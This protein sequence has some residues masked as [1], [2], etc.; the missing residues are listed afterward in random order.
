MRWLLLTLC[1]V[2]CIGP[3]ARAG[4]LSTQDFLRECQLAGVV[5]P[6]PRSE[7]CQAFFSAPVDVMQAQG[8][9]LTRVCRKTPLSG[10]DLAQFALFAMNDAHQAQEVPASETLFKFWFK[11]PVAPPCATTGVYWNAEM[12]EKQCQKDHGIHSACK[13]YTTSAV[14]FVQI[15][16]AL[17]NQNLFCPGGKARSGH[18]IV[19]EDE[20]MKNYYN[21]LAKNSDERR[22]SAG[23]VFVRALMA[24]NPC[25]R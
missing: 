8:N 21:Y 2:S 1:F 12:L 11:G 20:V 25:S 14:E 4:S 18:Y 7:N 22:H 16:A 6:G 23:D 13:F 19:S 24:A 5:K 17:K 3:A 10:S 9:Y 15:L